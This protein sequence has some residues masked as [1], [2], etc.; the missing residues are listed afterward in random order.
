MVE[1]RESITAK[2]CSFARAYH[3]NYER[4]KIF[5]DYLAYDIMGHEEYEKMG[6]LIEKDFNLELFNESNYF[7]KSKIRN[8]LNELISP[9]PLS[10]AAFAEKEL[11]RFSK[12]KGRCQ[13]VI[14]GAGMDTFAFRND[15]PE[16]IIYE[17]DHP[18]TQKYKMEKIKSL[19]WI[20]KDNV[21]FV[22]VDF[23]K[24]DM[25]EKLIESGFDI[26]MPS[27][28]AILGVT[29]YLM[30]G[31]FEQ[32]LEK[33]SKLS[34]Y[35]S[36]VVFDFPDETTFDNKVERVSRLSRITE[37][38]GEQMLYGYTTTEIEKALERHGFIIDEHVTPEKIQKEYFEGR[39]DGQRAYENIH[40][41]LARKGSKT[42][43]SYAM[44]I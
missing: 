15:N 6:Q 31:I 32:T 38:L 34:S 40:F 5:D 1:N 12:E 35:G 2:L 18:D 8:K 11:Y 17:I 37:Q 29:Y 14:C 39:V 4:P 26:K 23:S 25:S 16:I 13:Y 3:S 27:Y 33:I 44:N 42:I 43:D 10:R 24:D 9:I 36:K 41:I 19:E 20:V 21:R 28:F 30:L 7:C 22:P